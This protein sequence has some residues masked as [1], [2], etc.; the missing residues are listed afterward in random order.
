MGRDLRQL[1]LNILIGPL[2]G[3]V[4]QHDDPVRP[5]IYV[6]KARV[7]LFPGKSRPKWKPGAAAASGI[8]IVPQTDQV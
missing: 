3:Y 6:D 8:Q 4:Q 2:L 5:L 1:A 7:L